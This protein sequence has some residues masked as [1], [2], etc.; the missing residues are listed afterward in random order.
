MALTGRVAG[1]C[2]APYSPTRTR[3]PQEGGW[4]V[5]GWF[6]KDASFLKDLSLR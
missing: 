3:S 4:W 6:V 5:G 2:S 1:L